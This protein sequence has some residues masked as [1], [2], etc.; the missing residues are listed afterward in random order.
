MKGILLAGGTGSR[1]YP[2]TKTV[3]KQLLPVYDKPMVYYPLSTL[4]SLG[5]SEVLIVTTPKDKDSFQA[6]L[7]DGSSLGCSFSNAVQ[8]E[9]NGLAEAFLIGADFIGTDS[10]ALILGDN[11]F[12]GNSIQ[13]QKPSADFTGGLIFGSHVQNPERYGIVELNAQGKAKSIQ[14]KPEKPKSNLAIPG[15]YFFDYSVVEKAKQVKRSARGELEITD[16]NK[17][18]LNESS[19]EVKVLNEDTVWLDTGTVDSLMNA[20]QFVETLQQRKGILVGS[21]ELSAFQ[22]NLITK[23][24]LSLLV[25]SMTESKYG[26]FL[27]LNS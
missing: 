9:P 27:K 11:L 19:L 22:N 8:L 6:L 20:N 21:P 14:E 12:Y 26:E 23:E 25:E 5:I 13:K 17:A 15:L 16:I 4:L 24:T 1:L 10:V 3:S 7:G 2:I 18:F